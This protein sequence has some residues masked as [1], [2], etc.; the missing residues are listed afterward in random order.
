[1]LAIVA[2]GQ[3]AQ[4]PGFLTPWLDLPEVER[5]VR[6]A[7]SVVGRD[8]VALGT[9]GTEDEIRDTATC[10]PLLV[11]V[12]IAA[13]RHL[14]DGEA[15]APWYAGHSVGEL[16]AAALAGAL[17]DEAAL[18]LARER[19]AAMARAAAATPTGMSAILGGAAEKVEAAIAEAGLDVANVNGAGQVVAAGALDAL[20][21]LP[22]RLDGVA[23]VMP[24]RVAGAFHTSYMA[25]ARAALEALALPVNDPHARLLSNADGTVVA[26]G[27]ALVERLVAQ[28]SSPVRWDLC[29]ATLADAGVT[30]IVELPPAGTLTGL[31]KRELREATAVALRTPDDLA[32]ARRAVA[33]HADTSTGHEPSWRVVVAPCAGTFSPAQVERV[34]AGGALGRVVGRRDET[35]VTAA[36]AGVVIEWLALDGDPVKPGQP[37]VRLHPVSA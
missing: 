31:V 21:T 34:E 2:P 32:A 28:V 19:G 36:H 17:S 3:G 30:A 6:W 26:S 37:L 11:A 4:T 16:T 14:L 33:E 8:L 20:E 15:V 7:S 18:V 29:M 1:M 12:G 24:L 10:Q 23:R 5:S 27:T 13:G 35:T 22:V 9:T 25:P